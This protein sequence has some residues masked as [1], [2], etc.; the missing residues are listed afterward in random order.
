MFQFL[1]P[2]SLFHFNNKYAAEILISIMLLIL[3]PTDLNVMFDSL[4][5]LNVHRSSL[6]A[7]TNLVFNF[8]KDGGGGGVGGVGGVL[9]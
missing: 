5:C 2:R 8:H 7:F 6:L 3:A 9:Y 1:L 4:K